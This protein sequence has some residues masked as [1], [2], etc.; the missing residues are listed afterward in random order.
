MSISAP[1]IVHDVPVELWGK[2]HL[3]TLLYVETRVVDYKGV[4]NGDH[5]RGLY[6]PTTHTGGSTRRPEAHPTRLK[7][8][9]TVSPHDD[10][11]C[12][13][14]FVRE[15]LMEAVVEDDDVPD[16][17]DPSFPADL[18][19]MIE[20][21]IGLSGRFTLTDYGWTVA[22]ALRRHRAATGSVRDFEVPQ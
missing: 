13:A 15:G 10:V 6:I 21:Y 19:I 2:D 4:L 17:T 3:T 18:D 5:L 22:H 1:A 7:D 11:D 8:G 20:Q 16:D 14:D 12:L 9:A